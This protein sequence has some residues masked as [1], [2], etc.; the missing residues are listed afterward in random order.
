M[1]GAKG[2]VRMS[3]GA[4]RDQERRLGAS[5]NSKWR[6]LGTDMTH[7]GIGTYEFH[8]VCAKRF[9]LIYFM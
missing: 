7:V 9:N 1:K 2:R 4:N 8:S 5:C 6:S 3:G